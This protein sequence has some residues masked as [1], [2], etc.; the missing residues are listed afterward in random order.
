M[1]TIGIDVSPL[2]GPHRMR[3]IGQTLANVISNFDDEF[4]EGNK[5]I[6]FLE[7]ADLIDDEC[8]SYLNLTGF[9]FE[10]KGLKSQKKYDIRLPGK[11]KLLNSALQEIHSVKESMFGSSR[12]G[13]LSGV[14]V[15]L[16]IDQSS[17]LPRL[18]RKVK[19]VLMV[20]DLIPYVLEW[21]YLWNY[22]TAKQRGYSWRGALICVIRR[23]LYRLKIK[24]NTSRADVILSNS[25]S[26]KK[27]FS[28]YLK[29]KE[30][31]IKV[32]TLGSNAVDTGKAVAQY[33]DC[34]EFVKSSWGYLPKTLRI[35]SNDNYL[36]Y[37]GGVDPRKKMEELVSAFNMLRARGEDIKLVLLGDTMTGVDSIAN[38]EVRQALSS[39]SYLDDIVFL[40]FADENIKDW[41][42]KNAL[43]FVFTSRYEGFG[44][45]VIE[46]MRYGTPVIAY[47]N[48]ATFEV[49]GIYPIYTTGPLEVYRAATGIIHGGATA[50]KVGGEIEARYHSWEET[51]SRI[52]KVLSE[53]NDD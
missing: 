1:R 45:P 3:G 53:L 16:Q 5:L 12:T 4:R 39:S 17:S 43:A 36:L 44:L 49:A 10:V 30:P 9:K 34:V 26:T 25:E 47:R 24:C 50:T 42:Y 27:D 23:F 29:V 35:A 15:F 32:T 22:S 6:L 31:K 28:K 37:V 41:L 11:L 8:L 18:S 2:Q 40:G 48:E 7:G 13:S 14:D 52:A 38:T 51:S 19:K 46:A 20:H 21:D 33:V